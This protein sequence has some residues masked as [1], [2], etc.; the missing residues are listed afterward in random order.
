M[1][2]DQEALVTR[3]ADGI[4]RRR[5][6]LRVWQAA[7]FLTLVVL[8]VLWPRYDRNFGVVDPGRVYRSAQPYKGLGTLIREKK[9]GTILNLRGGSSVD[10]WYAN[11]VST[12]EAAGVDFYDFPM[13]ATRRPSRSELLVLLDFFERC[14][15]PLLIH[16]KQGSDRTGMAS[17]IYLMSMKSL[18]PGDAV[19]EFSIVYGHV[20]FSGT[21]RLHEPFDEYAAWLGAKSLDH[22]P[23]RFRNWLERE[24]KSEGREAGPLPLLPGPRHSVAAKERAAVGG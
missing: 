19:G 15:Y 3:D 22:T 8:A 2:L 20:P 17:A 9:L 5:R 10:P 14:R 1:N 6:W 21:R 12:T 23:A 18:P 4:P 16:C 11:E 24:Y 7:I 13:S